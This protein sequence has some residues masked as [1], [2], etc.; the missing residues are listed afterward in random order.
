MFKFRAIILSFIAAALSL[1]A[2]LIAPSSVQSQP[3]N[4]P[5][6]TGLSLP[7][8][9]ISTAT[10][11]RSALASPTPTATEDLPAPVLTLT[12]F[13]AQILAPLMAQPTW[14]PG[15]SLIELDGKPQFV[16]FYADWCGPCRDMRPAL[17][18]MK[19]KYKGQV[20]FW[21]INIDNPSSGRLVA[22]YQVQFIPYMVLLNPAGRLVR[23][24]EGTQTEESLDLALKALLKQ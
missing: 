11:R 9:P 4:S 18:K 16:E 2:M 20:T 1:A 14:T 23:T 17:L 22:R 6:P 8:L 13:S 24:L 10:P 15:P 21:D 3:A 19:E 7:T 12:A 5:T